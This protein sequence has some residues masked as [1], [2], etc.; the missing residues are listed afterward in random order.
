MVQ[1]KNVGV[2]RPHK[3]QRTASDGVDTGTDATVQDLLDNCAPASFGKNGKDVLDESYRKAVK[4]DV[5]QFSTNFNPY[6][7]G[8]IGAIAQTLLPGIAKP[9]A[10][11]AGEHTF[12]ESLGVIA[13]LYK[14]NVVVTARPCSQNMLTAI[15]Q[16]YSAPSGKFKPHVD[17]PCAITQ[18]GTLVVCLPYHHTGGQLRV[19]H[20]GQEM[21]YD[22]SDEDDIQWAAFYSDCEHEVHEVTAGHRITLT[23]NLY[24]HEQLGG[25]FR[26]PS[27][28]AMDSFSLYHCVK[29]ALA[30]PDFLPEGMSP[31][32]ILCS[33]CSRTPFRRHF[34]LSLCTRLPPCQ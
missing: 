30:I 27:T 15:S 33:L 22:W 34:R 4:L 6:E 5:D 13:E 32:P 24:A 17:T 29:E 21:T 23:Y 10:D 11:K 26:G 7:L 25:C 19:A 14:L 1:E 9:I 31:C 18:F 3:K 12:V 16:V 8:I 2:A 28:V 20:G